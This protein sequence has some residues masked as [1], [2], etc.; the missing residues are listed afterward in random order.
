MQWNERNVN[1]RRSLMF[2]ILPN[3]YLM[4][5]IFQN[6]IVNRNRCGLYNYQITIIRH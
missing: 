2:I 4:N 3:Q 6:L 5:H 1:Y